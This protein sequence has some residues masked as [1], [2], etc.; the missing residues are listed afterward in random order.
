MFFSIHHPLLNLIPLT[1]LIISDL[2]VGSM[3]LLLLLSGAI[4]TVTFAWM[5]YCSKQA[6][7]HRQSAHYTSLATCEVLGKLI[8]VSLTSGWLVEQLGYSA[9]YLIYVVLSASMLRCFRYVPVSIGHKD[10]SC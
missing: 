8:F 7:T 2:V 3:N 6:P 4:T 9:V 5:M 10:K 1:V